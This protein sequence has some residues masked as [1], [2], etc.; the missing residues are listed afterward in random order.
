M[1]VKQEMGGMVLRRYDSETRNG[2]NGIERD[3]IVK[4][5][6]GGMVLR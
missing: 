5:R 3:M 2:W 1:I 6:M 4:Q